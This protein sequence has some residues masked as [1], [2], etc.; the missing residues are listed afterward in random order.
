MA[1]HLLLVRIRSA[2]SFNPTRESLR[3]TIEGGL[4]AWPI[5]DMR[6]VSISPI[7]VDRLVK[8]R[9]APTKR[10]FPLLDFIKGN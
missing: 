9:R 3:S 10:S 7:P 8:P 5:E 4:V 2:D 1:E 6:L